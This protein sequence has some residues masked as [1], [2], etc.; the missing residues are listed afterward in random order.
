MILRYGIRTGVVCALGLFSYTETA[1][2]FERIK[3]TSRTDQDKKSIKKAV[4]TLNVVFPAAALGLCLF[5]ARGERQFP[6]V[7]FKRMVPTVLGFAGF[8]GACLGFGLGW[9]EAGIV[10]TK[11][12]NIGA[13]LCLWAC[14]Q[15]H[16]PQ[17]LFKPN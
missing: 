11:M 7:S 1:S 10:D 13:A 6:L 15:A 14:V 8:I 17:Y 3:K 16:L 9:R 2:A 4:I 5:G 12:Y